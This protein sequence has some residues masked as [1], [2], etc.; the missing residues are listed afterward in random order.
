MATLNQTSNP[1][2]VA[3]V[4]TSKE[5]I[6]RRIIMRA[7]DCGRWEDVVR[8]PSAKT[9]QAKN[10]QVVFGKVRAKMRL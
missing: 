4:S 5:K 3:R 7:H 9:F 6:A 8:E 10:S 1:E 2:N